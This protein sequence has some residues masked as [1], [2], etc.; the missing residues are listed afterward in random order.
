MLAV[1]ISA[2][3]GKNANRTL[4]FFQHD[5]SIFQGFP[6]TFK[7]YPLLGIKDLG[8]ARIVGEEFRIELVGPIDDPPCRNKIR[9]RTRLIEYP[10][11]SQ[12]FL[13]K[14]GDRFYSVL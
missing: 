14:E 4:L 10:V 12:L 1:L 9:V 3:S 8:F 5:C 11:F 7:K 13:G 6:H 2:A